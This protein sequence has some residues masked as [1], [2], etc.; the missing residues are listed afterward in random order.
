M[1]AQRRCTIST[2][3]P[4]FAFPVLIQ[5]QN[6]N[7]SPI[8]VPP[9]VKNITIKYGEDDTPLKLKPAEQVA[10]LFVYGIWGR[11]GNC[12]DKDMGIGRLCTMAELVS[13][14]KTNAGGT[15]GLSEDPGRDTNYSYDIITIGGDCVIRAIPRS[16][17]LG[18]FATVGSARRSSGNFYYN[19]KGADL[20]HAVKLTEYGYEGKGFTR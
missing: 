5:S 20:M 11:E 13:G 19:P 9:S 2:L 6:A 8:S 18:A 14:V 4:L 1:H 16:P 3:I 17:G 7:Q 10:F 15:I 12:L